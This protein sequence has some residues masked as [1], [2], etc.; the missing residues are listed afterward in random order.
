[1]GTEDFQQLEHYWN[2]ANGGEAMAN[3]V[4]ILHLQAGLFRQISH[5]LYLASLLAAMT[6][7]PAA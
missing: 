3:F 5:L 4:A 2:P 7:S 1:M 6:H